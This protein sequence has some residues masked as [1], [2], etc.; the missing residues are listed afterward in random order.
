[1]NITLLSGKFSCLLENVHRH[2]KEILL[3]VDLSLLSLPAPDKFPGNLR[4]ESKKSE[5]LNI[6]WTVS[7]LH[8]TSIHVTSLMV[9]TY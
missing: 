6:T 8:M 2:C 4:G 7:V 3:Y 1:M 5:E 9:D